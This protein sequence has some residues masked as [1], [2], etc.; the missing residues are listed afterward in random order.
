[1]GQLAIDVGTH[2]SLADAAVYMIHLSDNTAA[3]LLVRTLGTDNISRFMQQ[4][5]LSQSVLDLSGDG[6]NLTT[7]RDVLHELEA[8]AT[9]QMVDPDASKDMVD[10]MLGQEI[11]NLLPPGLPDGTPFAHKTGA[12]DY[13]LHDAGIVYSPAG[14]YIIV[15]MSSKLDDYGTAWTRMPELSKRV[16]DY[17]TSRSSDPVRYFPE[18]RQSV[19][20]DFLKFWNTYGGLTA[21]GFPLGPEEVE[22]G[23]LVQR[24]E[25][26]RFEWHPDSAGVGGPE[27]QLVLGALGSERAAKLGLTWK[28]GA[29]PGTGKYFSETGQ[30]TSGEFLNF[31]ENN[32]GARVFG[33]PISPAQMMVSPADGKTYMTQ[34]FERAR[35]E[36]HPDL[37]PGS[38]IVLASLGAEL[39]AS[40]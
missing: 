20:H 38:R 39:Q 37:P 17:F 28:P 29:D 22:N 3:A 25:R 16:Y 11:N 23:V 8:I 12:L 15:A 21:F 18:T 35:M 30:T 24:F 40:K 34:W 6:D 2:I 32:G 9:S 27:P 1:M 10:L 7:P 13:L 14:P 26:A 36:I 31:W 5:G 33:N 4:N 19:G